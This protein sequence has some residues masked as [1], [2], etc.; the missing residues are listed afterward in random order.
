MQDDRPSVLRNAHVVHTRHEVVWVRVPH[1]VH[2]RT[3]HRGPLV[4][5]TITRLDLGRRQPE[6]EQVIISGQLHEV[7][8]NLRGEV[9]AKAS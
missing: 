5:T 7:C 1:V 3:V 4:R 6:I 2:P 8:Q 9:E